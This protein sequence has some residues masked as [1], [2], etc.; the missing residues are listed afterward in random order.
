MLLENME[1]SH[2]GRLIEKRDRKGAHW[3]REKGIGRERAA[4]AREIDVLP[5]R[6]LTVAD[7]VLGR[8]RSHA[9]AAMLTVCRDC[10]LRCGLAGK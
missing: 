10:R 2:L 5:F 8:A 1:P 4:L 7:I 6:K 3:C 9:A